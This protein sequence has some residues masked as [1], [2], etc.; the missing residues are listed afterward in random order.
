MR[1]PTNPRSE[2]LCRRRFMPLPGAG[3]L[4]LALT[5]CRLLTGPDF[6][7]QLPGDPTHVRS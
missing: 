6:S 3:T 4:G 7:R 2:Y 1:A 5:G